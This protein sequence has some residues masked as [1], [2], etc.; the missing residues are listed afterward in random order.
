MGPYEGFNGLFNRKNDIG[1]YNVDLSASV[2][3]GLC[4]LKYHW[5]G[6]CELY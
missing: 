6:P 5:G 2:L 1:N 3:I 4:F